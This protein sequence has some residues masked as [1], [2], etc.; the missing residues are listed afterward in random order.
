MEME[1]RSEDFI[2]VEEL[3]SRLGVKKSWV[4]SRI[5][6]NSIPHYRIGKY[7]RFRWNEV[8]DWLQHMQ[9]EKL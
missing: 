6:T 7:R 3:A 9:G 8:E 4:Y 2:D 1:H 5:R